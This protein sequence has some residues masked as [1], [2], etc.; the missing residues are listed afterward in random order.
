MLESLVE[1]LWCQTYFLG[2]WLH[3]INRFRD[4]SGQIKQREKLIVAGTHQ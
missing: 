1:R 4:L 2:D 3:T